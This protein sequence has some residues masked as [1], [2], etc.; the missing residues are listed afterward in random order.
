MPTQRSQKKKLLSVW[1][2][3]KR[4]YLTK[5]LTQIANLLSIKRNKLIVKVLQEFTNIFKKEG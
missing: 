3:D 5:E 1:L 2:G 4:F